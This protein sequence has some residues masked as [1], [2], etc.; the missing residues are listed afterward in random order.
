MLKW[1]VND[2]NTR[3][4]THTAAISIYSVCS[5]V[6][7]EMNGLDSE[8]LDETREYIFQQFRMKWNEWYKIK[9]YVLTKWLAH[10]LCWQL[11]TTIFKMLSH[12]AH[13][14]TQYEF[15]RSL[16]RSLARSHARWL[17][18]CMACLPAVTEPYTP[19][20]V[21]MSVWVYE[22]TR[23]TAFGIDFNAHIFTMCTLAKWLHAVKHILFEK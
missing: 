13:T 15:D 9:H 16:A 20:R 6:R 17:K 2:T 22:W 7:N 11:F 1:N 14:K 23:F 3:T 8:K 21:R 10:L 12:A 4:R 5:L 19:I 18:A